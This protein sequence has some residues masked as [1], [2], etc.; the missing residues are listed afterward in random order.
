MQRILKLKPP[1]M[2]NFFSYELPPRPRQ[3]GINIGN[4]T[5]PITEFSREEA[6][7][8]GELMKQTFIK[9]W[10]NKIEKVSPQ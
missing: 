3:E 4:A 5:I 2:P 6:E 7:E 10:E 9:H 1:Q 8:F